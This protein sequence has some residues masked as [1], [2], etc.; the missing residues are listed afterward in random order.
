MLC[1]ACQEIF[2]KREFVED[3]IQHEVGKYEHSTHTRSIREAAI[4]NGCQ[5]CAMLC[6]HFDVEI[7]GRQPTEK[8]NLR[9]SISPVD[10]DPGKDE[11]DVTDDSHLSIRFIYENH[12]RNNTFI[13][14]LVEAEKGLRTFH[15]PVTEHWL[16]STQISLHS[17]AKIR[18]CCLNKRPLEKL[19]QAGR[20]PWLG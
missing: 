12:S 2:K 4:V 6:F 5:I 14:F 8:L 10:R 13:R 7:P 18:L 20:K 17:F 15:Y 11:D 16:T 19:H 3:K 9:Y 1:S